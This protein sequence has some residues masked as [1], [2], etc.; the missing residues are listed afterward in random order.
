MRL[1][2]LEIGLII[3]VVLL[4]LVV[5]R[6]VRTGHHADQENKISGRI[7]EGKANEKTGRGRR[8]RILGIISILV[9]IILLSAGISLFKWVFWS[10]LWSFIVMAI[11][12]V[13][14]FISRK[15]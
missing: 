10:Y 8:L 4:I 2:P 15:R 11:G 6:M 7:Q 5:T 13:I 9:G 1:G 14:I 12:F 3:L